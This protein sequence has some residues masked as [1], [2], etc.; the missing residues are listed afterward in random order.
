LA[1]TTVSQEIFYTPP[2]KRKKIMII[3]HRMRLPEKSPRRSFAPSRQTKG[4][5][6]TT[7]SHRMRLPEKS[8]R[9]SF[10][11]SRQTKGRR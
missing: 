2:D 9:R 7:T 3:S 11:P 1:H 8:P 6:I 4:R 10:A 5:R